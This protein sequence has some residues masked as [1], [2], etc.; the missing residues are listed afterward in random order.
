M[1]APRLPFA[2]LLTA[3]LALPACGASMIRNTTVADTA[4]NREV[5]LFVD[6]YRR[7]L[8]DRNTAA[9]LSLVSESYLDTNGTLETSDDHDFD[10]LRERMPELDEQVLDVR[11]DV[12][13][14]NVSFQPDR[15][16]V[17]FRY[18][19]SFKLATPDGDRWV[20]RF[21]EH[22]VIL[23]KEEGELRILSGM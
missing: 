5:L 18:S 20:R 2:L 15:I 13:Y 9:L 4:E 17:D 11:Y 7:A 8:E 10:R 6:R 22:R 19:A 23:V 3:A 16:F 14:R 12:M 1:P 21:S